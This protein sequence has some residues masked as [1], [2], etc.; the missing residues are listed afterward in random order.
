[1]NFRSWQ[2]ALVGMPRLTVEQWRDLDSVA[3]WLVATRASVLFLT[4]TSVLFG[5][6]LAQRDDMFRWLPFLL[7]V[8]GL[9]MAH[10]TN[11]LLND[12]SDWRRGIDNDN[13]YRNQYGVHVLD[14]GLVS[15]KAFWGYVF[16]TAALE[17]LPG[18]WLVAEGGAGVLLLMALG[19]FFVI[20]YTWPLKYCGLGEPA[21]LLVWGPLMV[22]GTYYVI[23]GQ[24][25]NPAAC[26]GL[27]FACG[28]TA[29]LFGK[30][31]DKMDMDRAKQ[32]NTL[33][34]LLGEQRAR[35]W[36]A[37]LVFLQ[38]FATVVLVLMGYWFW[39]LLCVLLGLRYFR[40]LLQVFQ[41]PKPDVPPS[42][43]PNGVWPLWFAAYSFD[44]T[45]RFTSLLLLGL[46]LDI[47]L[48]SA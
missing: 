9:V 40:N 13:Y 43:L 16:F 15:Q 25:S 6:L 32:V 46:G 34:V 35:Y 26:L 2:Q 37:S 19:A 10:A 38:Y 48:N 7:C 31:I 8:L 14:S 21:V 1:M 24:W 44:H 22:G 20:F 4:L 42:D 28:P 12:F 17:I 36:A 11:N 3:R 41:D 30:H 29:V 47:L 5:G 39:S 18:L 27:L 23:T 33:P 45:R